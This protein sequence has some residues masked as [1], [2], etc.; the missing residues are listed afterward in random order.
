MFYD[1][2]RVLVTGGAGL[3]GHALVDALLRRGAVVWATVYKERQLEL[4]HSQLDITPCDLMQPDDCRRIVRD[5]DIV[6]HAAAYIRGVK[7]RDTQPNDIVMNNLISSVNVIDASC[8][9]GVARFGWIGSSTVYPDR[10]HPLREEEAFLDDP[11]QQYFGIGWVKRYCEKL[12]MHYHR[13]TNT[14]FAM[15][16]SAAVY[17]P[18]ERF[19]LEDG[20]VLPALI[21]KAVR[22][23]DP[24]PVWGD[25][26]DVRDFVYVDDLVDGFLLTMEHHA[27]A[28]PINIATGT[29][30]R[31]K[32]AVRLILEHEGFRPRVAYQTDQ[33]SV[34]KTR[35]LDVSKAKRLLGF[36]ARTSFADGLAKTIEWYKSTLKQEP[37]ASAK[38]E[39]GSACR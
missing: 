13:V 34:K 23:M 21:I 4:R 11:L 15:I 39:V 17:G 25:G 35:L 3:I 29:G 9:A 10:E 38:T 1:G 31:I 32:D 6:F 12:C 7:G 30:F 27:A 22:R 19:T 28:D 14:K 36:E 18:H 16:R 33:P 5:M 24:Y 20:H 26:E 8:R 37:V 2:K